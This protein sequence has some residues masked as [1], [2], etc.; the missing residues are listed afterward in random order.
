MNNEVQGNYASVNGLNMYFV[1]HGDG[2]PLM[3]LHGA[4]MMIEHFGHLLPALAKTRRVIAPEMQAHGHTNDADRPL[5]YEQM[6]DDTAALMREIGVENADIYGYS[7]GAAAGLQLA[8]RHPELVR[9]LVCVSGGFS[10]EGTQPELEAFLPDITP[11][12]FE[13]SPFHE[14]YLRAA[15]NPENFPTLVAKLKQLDTTPFAWPAEDVGG[16]AAPTMV[17]A[18]DADAVTLEHTVELFRLL[19]GGGM[20]DLGPLPPSRLA[21]LPATSHL[22]MLERTELLVPMVADFLDAP[23]P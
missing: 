13:G 7:M 16:I 6:A 12:V 15:P 20:G 9:K 4:Y 5:T 21:V 10:S 11:E 23:M 14:S 3:L 19:G 2:A 22:G 8:I 1:V 17:V 18:G